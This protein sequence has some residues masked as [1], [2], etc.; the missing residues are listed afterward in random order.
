MNNV[1]ETGRVKTLDLEDNILPPPPINNKPITKVWVLNKQNEAIEIDLYPHP[2]ENK[3][4]A[5]F[6]PSTRKRITPI[7]A[8]P[9][10]SNVVSTSPLSRKSG[11]VQFLKS[12]QVAQA[13]F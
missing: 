6:S 13:A 7:S 12:N 3:L 4:S 8:P 9:I 2:E 5:S 10:S 1:T 11:S